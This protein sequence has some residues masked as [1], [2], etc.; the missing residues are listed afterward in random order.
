QGSGFRVQTG[1]SGGVGG[2]ERATEIS[3][4]CSR[5]MWLCSP[6]GGCSSPTQIVWL[7]A[8]GLDYQVVVLIR[9]RPVRAR[10]TAFAAAAQTQSPVRLIAAVEKHPVS[11]S[12]A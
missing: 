10:R 7:G 4:C 1:E 5:S 9:K 6:S 12:P 11:A 8:Q 2:W 3:S